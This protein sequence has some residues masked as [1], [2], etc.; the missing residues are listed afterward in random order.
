MVYILMII[1]LLFLLHFLF[2]IFQIS[3]LTSL[4]N[5]MPGSQGKHQSNH[6][7]TPAELYDN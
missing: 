6:R 2:H 4:K 7:L 3:L 1:Y 5:Y